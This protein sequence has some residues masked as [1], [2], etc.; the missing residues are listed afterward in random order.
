MANENETPPRVDRPVEPPTIEG[1]A[2]EIREIHEPLQNEPEPLAEE[3]PDQGEIVSPEPET[4]E[5]RVERNVSLPL[6]VAVL[7]LVLAGIGVSAVAGLID[8]GTLA[9]RQNVEPRIAS[10]EATDRN[11][12]QKIDELTGAI[13]RLYEQRQ[14][15]ASGAP[16]P[17]SKFEEQIKNL[18]AQIAGLSGAVQEIG[19]SLKSIESVQSAQQENTRATADLVKELN[20]RASA[21]PPASQAARQNNAQVA[22]KELAGALLRLRRAVQE[23][24]PFLQELQAIQP[25][26]PEAA[27]PNLIELSGNGVPSMA[28][29]TTQLRTIADQ[30]KAAP[31][32]HAPVVAPA[33]VWDSLKSKAASLVSVRRL[34]EAENVDLVATAV[35]LMDKGNLE[36]AVQVLDSVREPRPVTIETWIHDAQARLAAEK[37]SE[38]LTTKVLEQLG[39]SL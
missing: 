17:D 27:D 23:G 37:A 24:R 14:G 6:I 35:Q 32:N 4:A 21:E 2:E 36:G 16:L 9:Q 15:V 29:L 33:G 38:G 39:S 13:N 12:G 8:F 11:I 26:V 30:Q 19:A 31:H 1:E 10:I 3:Q 7:A 5:S 34:G 25:T 18:E 28:D 22:S 20:S